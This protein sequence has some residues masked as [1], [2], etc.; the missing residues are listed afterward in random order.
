MK[1]IALIGGPIDLWPQKLKEI[2]DKNQNEIIIGV[3]RGALYLL[4]LGIIPDIAIGDFDS[5]KPDELL[6]IEKKVLDIRYS[7]PIKDYTDTESMLKTALIDY[8]VEK[9]QIYGATGGRLDHFL[10]TLFTVI[11]PEFNKYAEKVELIDQQ[12]KI[13]FYNPGS[14]RVPNEL[15]YKYFGVIILNKIRKLNIKNARYDLKSY[16]TDFPYSFASNEF[17]PESKYFDLSFDKG[18]VAIIYSK[19]IKRFNNL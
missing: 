2:I 4:E 8:N 16:N 18:N 15:E 11:N 10:S 12:N 13:I 14:Y 5:L 9:L 3:D 1:A 17:L 19:D 7:N 6:E